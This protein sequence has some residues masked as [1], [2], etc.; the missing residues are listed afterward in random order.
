LCA[1]W[2]GEVDDEEGDDDILDGE[3]EVLAISR[4]W[5]AVARGVGEGDTVRCSLEYLLFQLRIGS[6]DLDGSHMPKEIDL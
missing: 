6:F 4:E 1:R 5:E 3:E 2:T